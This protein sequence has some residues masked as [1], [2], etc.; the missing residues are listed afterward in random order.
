M[1]IIKY[2]MIQINAAYEALKKEYEGPLHFLAVLQPIIKYV[3]EG[4]VEVGQIG[5]VPGR[6]YVVLGSYNE[7]NVE[8]SILLDP[9]HNQLSCPVEES[10]DVF[11]L[12]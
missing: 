7:E 4:L 2:D 10:E 12:V 5:M 11:S 3:A 1:K 6:G 8:I 9:S